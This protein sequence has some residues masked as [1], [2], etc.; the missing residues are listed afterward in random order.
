MP[1]KFEHCFPVAVTQLT[2]DFEILILSF[3]NPPNEGRL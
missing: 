1:F 2:D 3:S